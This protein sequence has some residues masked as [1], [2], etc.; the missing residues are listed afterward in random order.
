MTPSFFYVTVYVIVIIIYKIEWWPLVTDA[1]IS[2]IIIVTVK[3]DSYIIITEIKMTEIEW[4]LNDPLLLRNIN[5]GNLLR[6][7]DD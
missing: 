5:N 4:I 2:V 6:H 3:K 1:K 7:N